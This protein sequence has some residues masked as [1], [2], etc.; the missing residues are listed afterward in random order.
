[1]LRLLCTA[2]KFKSLAA[3]IEPPAAAAPQSAAKI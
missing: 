3:I 1:M 2:R